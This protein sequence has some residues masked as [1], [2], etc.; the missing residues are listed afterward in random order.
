[1]LIFGLGFQAILMS[2]LTTHV[3]D[4]AAGLPAAGLRIELHDLSV[5]PPHRLAEVHTNQDGRCDCP[6]LEGESLR[7][8]YSL[9]FYV[10]EY[11]RARGVSLPEP[12][13]FEDVVVRFGIANGDQSYPVPLLVSPWSYSTYRGS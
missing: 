6:L 4:L 13:F 9:T 7:G 10:A 8:R 1:M 3:L 12:A 5:T 11:F 2:R